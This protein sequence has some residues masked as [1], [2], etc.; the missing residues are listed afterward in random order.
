MAEALVVSLVQINSQTRERDIVHE[1]RLQV[2]DFLPITSKAK[3]LYIR[4]VGEVVEG[5]VEG[6]E[7]VAPGFLVAEHELFDVFLYALESGLE[8]KVVR[9]DCQCEE[10]EYFDGDQALYE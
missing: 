10:Q 4:D 8:G 7:V 6:V 3:G 1:D 5:L 2:E 9:D